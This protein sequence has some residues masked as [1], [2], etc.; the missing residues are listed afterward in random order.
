[1]PRSGSLD[2]VNAM[3]NG[4]ARVLAKDRDPVGQ[5]DTLRRGGVDPATPT[6]TQRKLII[7]NIRDGLAAASARHRRGGRP[8]L[9]PHQAQV[10]Q[11]RYDVGRRT[12][13]QIA[14]VFDASPSTVYGYLDKASIGKRTATARD[15]AAERD[16][17]TA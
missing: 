7:A 4:S 1:M 2:I 10:T 16:A 6:S 13:Q 15:G 9:I 14:G 3:L 5:V 17:G 11:Q 12:V 8:R